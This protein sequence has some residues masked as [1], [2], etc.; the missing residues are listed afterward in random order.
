MLTI[1][2]TKGLPGSGKTTWAKEKL[3]LLGLNAAKRTNKDELRAMLDDGKY[4]RKSEEFIVDT[5]RMIAGR[6]L[7]SG[8]HLIVDN[9]GFSS[10]H[11]DF[12]RHLAKEVKANFEIV[13][14]THVPLEECINRDLRRPNSV[15]EKA[16]RDMHKKYLEVKVAPPA[17][18]SSLPNAVICDLDGTL[19]ILN[20]RNPYDASTC[21]EDGLN[22]VVNAALDGVREKFKAKL[23]F[24]SGRSDKYSGITSNWLMDN[25]SFYKGSIQYGLSMREEGDCR[26]DSII[27]REIYE[28]HIQGKYNVVAIFD[29]R[30]Q[31]IRECWQALGFSDRI[32]NVGTGEEF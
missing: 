9:T 13:D 29:D 19:A 2:Y 28:E 23:I 24:V 3:D 21:M 6:V 25:L 8:K 12:Y 5:E 32:F 22:V 16:I 26:R 17:Y 18:D 11:E 14:F 10:Y 31:V 20:S 1:Y 7:A 4:S 30:P 27:K 15:G